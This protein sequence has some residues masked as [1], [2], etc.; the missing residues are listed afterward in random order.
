VRKQKPTSHDG[1]GDGGAQAPLGELLVMPAARAAASAQL[2]ARTAE[3]PTQ[4]PGPRE[5]PTGNPEDLAPPPGRVPP[6]DSRSMRRTE[7]AREAFVLIYR[8]QTHVIS[9]FGEVGRLGA[10][11]V[12]QYPTSASASHAYA[13][14]CSR[15]V[16]EGFSDYRE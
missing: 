1:G 2:D 16:S 8:V 3:D 9:R 13:K 7:A 11:R 10:W 15:F 14:G 4:M 12:V 6:G 5:I